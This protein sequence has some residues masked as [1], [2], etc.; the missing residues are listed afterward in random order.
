MIAPSRGISFSVLSTAV[1][2][3]P[4][5]RLCIAGAEAAAIPV[6]AVEAR[7]GRTVILRP[8][9]PVVALRPLALDRFW[10]AV[11]RQKAVSAPLVTNHMVLLMHG[12]GEYCWSKQ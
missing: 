4:D 3:R 1:P 5:R 6:P 10:R 11:T 9:K 12:A 8:V 7:P 2:H